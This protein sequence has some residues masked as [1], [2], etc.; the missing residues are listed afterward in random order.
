MSGWVNVL[1]LDAP[2]QATEADYPSLLA[3]THVTK[4]DRTFSSVWKRSLYHC[5]PCI[6]TN[7]FFPQGSLSAH[8]L[9][10]E[11]RLS[12]HFWG[13]GCTQSKEGGVLDA[14][15]SFYCFLCFG[16]VVFKIV[17]QTFSSV[18][19]RKIFFILGQRESAGELC[20]PSRTLWIQL[21]FEHFPPNSFFWVQ[22]SAILVQMG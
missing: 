22:K 7:V 18:D 9:H 13:D 5:P 2:D 6:L 11:W 4:D 19:F 3:V 8:L 12:Y 20:G 16:W 21:V 15:L 14:H 17:F 1:A 10:P